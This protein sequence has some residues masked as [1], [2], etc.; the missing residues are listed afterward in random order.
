MK[1]RPTLHLVTL[2]LF[3]SANA[4]AQVTLD[5]TLGHAGTLP[6]PNYQ[7]GADLGQ[8]HGGNL[9]HSFQDFNLQSHESA[10]FSGPDNVQ[11]II[12][13]VTGGNLS[14]IDGTLR[15]TIPNADLYFLNPYGIMFG[16]TAK[17]DVQGGF[18]ASTADYLRL[19][20]GGRFDARQPSNSLLTIAPPTAF[21]FLE[22]PA[23]IQVQGSQLAVA[24]HT[25]FSLMG[26]N[27]TLNQAQL[28]A[29]SG[30]INLVSVA[31]PGE[32]TAT[33]ERLDAWIPDTSH[34]SQL[35]QIQME[36]AR[37]E[38]SG[39]PAGGISIRGGQFLMTDSR[40]HAHNYGQDP[41][42]GIDIELRDSMTMTSEGL[43]GYQQADYIDV[44]G[45]I[46]DTFATGQAGDVAI[47]VP[48]LEMRQVLIDVSTRG[49][50]NGGNLD[51]QTQQLSLGEATGIVSYSFSSGV[52]GQINIKATDRLELIDPR[53]F[54]TAEETGRN[55]IT[56]ILTSNF[57]SGEG[58]HITI[59]TP[60]LKLAGG[61]I[62]SNILGQGHGGTVRINTR[63]MELLNGGVIS[64]VVLSQATG[65]SGEIKL[66][67]SDTLKLSGFRPGFIAEGPLVLYNM[68]SGIGPITLGN[69]K[70]GLL[71]ITAKNLIISDY[72]SV[73][74]TTLG[75]GNAGVMTISVDN[76]Y[77]Q[78]GGILTNSSGTVL[79]GKLFLATGNGGN[80]T[81]TAKEDIVIEGRNPL[82]PSSI[83]TNTFLSGQGGSIDLQANRLI[84]RDSG[85]ITANS[86]GS[87][88]AG[89]IHIK[90]NEIHLSQGGEITSAAMQAVGGNLVINPSFLLNLQ[91]G[92]I[93]TSVRSGIG[94]G[95][96][97]TIDHPQFVV[98]N[99]GQIIAQADAGHG[100]N[101]HIVAQQFLNTPD[102]LISASSRLGLDGQVVIESPAEKISGSL[103]ALG[104]TFTEVSG[105]LPG[106]CTEL[107]F[108]EFI[109]RSRFTF[110]PIVGSSPR[111]DDLKP[112]SL[113]LPTTAAPNFTKATGSKAN[114]A[115][116][117]QRLAWLTG[118][119]R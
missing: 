1:K 103:L 8:P 75:V 7:I 48:R 73:G 23:D 9:F 51:I 54:T 35:G 99:Q 80:L 45:I 29:E 102:S 94:S 68:Q 30:R 39:S 119:H 6:G 86:L 47:R 21:G 77:L 66:N 4:H 107:S 3:V 84:L 101:I 71:E 100:G 52:G 61:F 74:S 85:T 50:G 87:G 117:T 97:I 12:S 46:S 17:L 56:A 38:T 20:D 63:V 72:A 19:Q 60:S 116:L 42:K 83:A 33:V 76:L 105:L 43:S 78:D 57:G 92:Q 115:E 28:T 93:T 110:N 106:F 89:D 5:G 2:T 69:G 16:P 26:G 109:N 25:D 114:K 64:S 13:R 59:D 82:Y 31:S 118:C 36:N 111:P 10:T 24:P 14:S 34:F 15:S 49:E 40:I 37:V 53:V 58:G 41:G 98:M 22:S 11:N 81:V 44:P 62:A 113:L 70:G 18:H 91:Q 112:S 104:T 95:G 32:V 27:L 55:A 108:E 65:D 67:V 96:N 79:G 90:A 88:N